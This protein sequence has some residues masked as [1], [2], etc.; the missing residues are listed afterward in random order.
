MRSAFV[1]L[2][3]A[4]IAPA[5]VL[6]AAEPRKQWPAP[7]EMTIDPAKSYTATLDTTAGKIVLQ[8]SASEAPK[9]VNNFVFLARQGFYD[10]TIFHRVIP[11]FMIQ[12]GDPTGTGAGGPGYRFE[13][14]NKS[15]KQG[16]GPGTLAMANA[17][18]DTNGSQFFINDAD[19]PWLKPDKYTIFGKVIDGLDVVRAIAAAPR[20]ANDR[21][22]EPTTI[23]GIT[24]EEK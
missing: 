20:G 13:N 14:E 9:T 17:G 11:G 3:L 23:R 1:T 21:P 4:L 10:G 22:N 15:S 16:F 6:F 8:L 5:V 12:G 7:P 19:S 24:I 18:P 2:L